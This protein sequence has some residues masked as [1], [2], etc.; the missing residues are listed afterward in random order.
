ME[1]VFFYLKLYKSTYP[2][3]SLLK[4]NKEGDFAIIHLKKVSTYNS[5][6]KDYVKVIRSIQFYRDFDY[7]YIID[8]VS[9]KDKNLFINRKYFI[10]IIN[11]T[12]I[13][14]ILLRK[15]DNAIYSHLSIK[16]TKL[17]MNLTSISL[18]GFFKSRLKKDYI[19]SKNF[20]S[21]RDMLFDQH[22]LNYLHID[23]ESLYFRLDG[24]HVVDL[25]LENNLKMHDLLYLLKLYE[26]NN[27]LVIYLITY[28]I[29]QKII[30][31]HFEFPEI[32]EYNQFIKNSK[33]NMERK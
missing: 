24:M 30:Y 28:W 20:L 5:Y 17:L 22:L 25:T 21:S 12:Q 8:K 13:F 15:R 32:N 26:I 4:L 1:R 2:I 7:N 18:K 19:L 23:F 29:I 3:P 11:I 10:T 14:F 16:I 9:P 27:D 33:L 31:Y 6:I